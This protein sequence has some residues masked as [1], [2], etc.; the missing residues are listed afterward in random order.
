MTVMTQTDTIQSTKQPH[1]MSAIVQAR[2][3]SLFSHIVW[4]SDESDAKKIITA[5]LW[6]TG[7][8]HQDSLVLCGW[9]LSSKTWNPITSPWMKQLSTL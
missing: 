9:R 7:G 4:L 5:P 6:R 8:D 3:F 1:P 2:R